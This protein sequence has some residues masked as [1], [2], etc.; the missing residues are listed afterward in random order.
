LSNTEL[1]LKFWRGD[2]IGAERLAATVLHIDGFSSVDPQCPLGGPDGLKDVLCEKNGWR[3]VAAA[4]FPT[5][6]QKFNSVQD[7]FRHD[8]V[9][10]SKNAAS[11]IVFLTN[12]TLTPSERDVLS[13]LATDLGHKSI[14]YHLERLRALLDS[15]SGYGARLE[16]LDIDMSRE[17]QLSF[18][19][20]WNRSF[21]DQL[22][23]NGLMIIREISKK[24]DALAGATEKYGAQVQEMSHVVQQTRSLVANI[25]PPSNKRD[26]GLQSQ[27]FATNQLT[28]SELCML[29]RALLFD[30]PSA[31]QVGALRSI[32]IWIGGSD[33]AI[34]TASFV[35][36]DP[37][38][39]PHLLEELLSEWRHSFSQLAKASEPDR[40]TA[41]TKFHHRFLSIHPFVDGNGRIAR[42]LLTQHA[43]E[44]LH[45]NRRVF[46]DDSPSYFQALSDA[47]RGNYAA[48]EAQITQAIFGVEFI[49]GSPCQMSGQQCPSCRDGVMDVSADEAGVICSACGLVIAAI[50]P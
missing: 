23:A 10:V 11:G 48:L 18:F 19:S 46:I 14:L 30:A 28:V 4:Y 43:R 44:L 37:E 9:G 3:Y 41:I 1:K 20:Q 31:D 33:A 15:P 13:E 25:V 47:D 17:E 34:T 2:Q 38:H 39:V 32:K 5:S 36:P 26:F 40:L 27:D 8:L 12:Q 29:H 6:E 45:Q 16:F 42:F 22:Q 7:K 21:S 24:I 49:P 50:E 35:P